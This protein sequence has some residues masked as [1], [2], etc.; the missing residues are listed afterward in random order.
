MAALGFVFDPNLFQPRE[1][2]QDQL[3]EVDPWEG[4]DILVGALSLASRGWP[5]FPCKA[6]KKP[7][8]AN[9]FY[10]A[11]LDPEQIKVMFS[12]PGA[13]FI[14]VPM[15]ERSGLIAIDL[16]LHGDSDGSSWYEE[17]FAEHPATLM[18]QTR[19][20]GCHL[21]YQMPAGIT[22]K[23]SVGKLAAGVDVRGEGGYVIMPPSPGYESLR[24][25]PPAEMPEWLVLA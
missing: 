12:R 20:G 6:D 7:A 15:G 8:T 17:R 9:G 1:H 5:V 18:H 22:I 23:N 14:A 16:D 24:D 2:P 10:D 4:G 11:S 19:S 3:P 25:L 21:L 13:A